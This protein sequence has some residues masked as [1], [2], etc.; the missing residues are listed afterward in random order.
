MD[1]SKTD[2]FSFSEALSSLKQA[3][4]SL[5]ES[6]GLSEILSLIKTG[7]DFPS[8]NDSNWSNPSKNTSTWANPNKNTSNWTFKDKS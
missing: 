7:W 5:S 8:R 1:F 2:A 3:I 6:L 4:V